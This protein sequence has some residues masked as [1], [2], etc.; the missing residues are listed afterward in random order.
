MHTE[1]RLAAVAIAAS[2]AL[3]AVAALTVASKVGAGL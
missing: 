1:R 2:I 3:W